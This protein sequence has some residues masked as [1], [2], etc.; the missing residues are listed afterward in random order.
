MAGWNHDASLDW[1]LLDFDSHARL[2]LLVGA[3]NHLYRTEPALQECDVDPQG[4]EW[5]DASDSEK[6]IISYMRKG[7]S[8][9]DMLLVVCHFSPVLRTNYRVGA[10]VRGYWQEILN[11]DAQ[12][13][14]G[15]GDGNSR[16]HAYRSHSSAWTAVFSYHHCASAVGPGI[17]SSAR[18]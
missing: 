17:P 3:L 9:G 11:T 13:F 6:N 7:K 10:P 5:I 18:E 1:A 2:R 15:A 16:W 8:A 14:G 12:I 4:F